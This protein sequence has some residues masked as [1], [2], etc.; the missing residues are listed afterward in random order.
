MRWENDGVPFAVDADGNFRDVASVARGLQCGCFCADCKGP[1]VAKKGDIKAHHFAHHDRRDCRHSLEA[2]L[3]GMLLTFTARQGATLMLP[4]CGDR[5]E[6]VPRPSEIFTEK[7]AADFFRTRWVIPAGAVSLEGA[8]LAEPDLNR[9][10]VDRADIRLAGIEVHV[11]SHRKREADIAQQL[12]RDGPAV[13]LIDLREYASNWWRVCDEHKHETLN[14]AKSATDVMTKWIEHETGG[15]RWL[16]HPELEQKKNVLEKWIAEKSQVAAQ[17]RLQTRL[18]CVPRG[19]DAGARVAEEKVMETSAQA[20]VP[21]AGDHGLDLAGFVRNVKQAHSFTTHLA[22]ECG[23]SWD[24]VE[25]TYVYFG[26]PGERVPDVALEMFDL[27]E[28]WRPVFGKEAARFT[29]AAKMLREAVAPY[30]L[31]AGGNPMEV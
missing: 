2:S 9:S 4:P 19:V 16:F 13:L 24:N 10:T 26:R 14:A 3:F 28:E 6:L 22:A 15:R 11:L 31:R 23:L 12:R 25:H 8:E 29:P 1:L 18:E 5:H 20:C 30:G 21:G 27:K 7:Q 17:R